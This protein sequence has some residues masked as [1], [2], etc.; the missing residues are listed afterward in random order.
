MKPRLPLTAVLAAAALTACMTPMPWDEKKPALTGTVWRWTET[1]M[2]DDT[3]I[4]PQAPERYTLEL[5]PDGTARVR[6]DCN[7]GGGRYESG[8]ERRIDLTRIALSQ[9]ACLPGSQG[10]AYAKGL[11]NVTS[12]LFAGEDLVLMLKY[13]SGTMRFVP[14][15]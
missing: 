6:S 13:D 14:R 3:R 5:L 1:L 10:D 2:N 4:R 8:A 15:R 11:A 7:T 9:A 12:Y